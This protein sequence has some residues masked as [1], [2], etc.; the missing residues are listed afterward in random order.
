MPARPNRRT[1]SSEKKR[2]GNRPTGF[3]LVEL[4]VV[5][6]IIALL[7]SIILPGLARA[8]DGVKRV[9]CL[10]N[11]RSLLAA[12]RAF[13]NEHRGLL[14]NPNWLSLESRDP[15]GWLY[16]SPNRG[17][18]INHRRAGQLWKYL[19]GSHDSYRCPAHDISF[20]KGPTEYLTSYIM[21]GSV[22]GYGGIPAPATAYEYRQF[23]GDAALF[24]EGD[25]AGF[26]DGSSTPNEVQLSTRHGAAAVIGCFDGHAEFM[27]KDDW[28]AELN[29]SPG[30]L[31]CSPRTANGH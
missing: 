27:N 9:V 10:N 15:V 13:S 24:V 21:N 26:N 2:H 17:P 23:A 6:G 20:A 3:T 16:T 29:R 8:R 18:D 22:C 31:W 25:E 1:A 11:A 7:V 28:A 5:I 14:P 4:L 19:G 30:R 12:S